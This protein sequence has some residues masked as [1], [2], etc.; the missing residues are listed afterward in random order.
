MKKNFDKNSTI[1]ILLNLL[2]K[3]IYKQLHL[4]MEALWQV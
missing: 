3:K 2:I 1:E 4:R